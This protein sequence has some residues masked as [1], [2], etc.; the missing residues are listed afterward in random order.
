[1]KF[2]FISY[3]SNVFQLCTFFPPKGVCSYFYRLF[4]AQLRLGLRDVPQEEVCQNPYVCHPNPMQSWNPTQAEQRDK[5]DAN[6]QIRTCAAA[7]SPLKPSSFCTRS[8]QVATSRGWEFPEATKTRKI[9]AF[10]CLKHFTNILL[11]SVFA[12]TKL[13]RQRQGSGVITHWKHN[14]WTHEKSL[15]RFATSSWK[16]NDRSC[17]ATVDQTCSASNFI[18]RQKEAA[19]KRQVNQIEV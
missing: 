19:K 18:L 3:I 13:L 15:R 6:G 8:C 1:M 14:D 17:V 11:Q 7:I 2:C 12:T 5:K 4:G 16:V 9:K 10:W